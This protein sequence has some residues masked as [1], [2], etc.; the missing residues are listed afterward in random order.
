MTVLHEL[1]ETGQSPW[2]DNIT[3]DLLFSGGLKQLIDDGISGLTSNPT[4]FQKAF[5]SSPLYKNQLEEIKHGEIDTFEAYEQLAFRDI[6]DATDCFEEVYESSG[7]IDG[8]VS[9]EVSPH[10]AH[11]KEK[12]IVEARRTFS[13][14]DRPNLMIK[15]P[16]TDEGISAIMELISEGVN[17]NATLIFSVL[18]YEKTANAYIEGLEK[19]ASEG[20]DLSAL[21]SVASVFISRVD[22][23]VDKLLD[24]KGK[25][26]LKGLTAVAN[27]KMIYRKFK[28]IFSSERFRKLQEKGANV[29]RVLWASTSS[30]NPA[31]S[32]IKYVQELIGQ[33]T[34]NTMP[35][36]TMKAFIESGEARATVEDNLEEARRVLSEVESAGISVEEVCDNLQNDGVRKFIDSF[37]SLLVSI[38]KSIG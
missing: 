21:H 10:Y 29:Q 3:R 37:D 17:I 6:L 24:E 20:G 19:R 12:T 34:V 31:Y 9:I 8:Y 26:S 36:D 5:G 7:K 4:I 35:E 1:R 32:P 30:K 22:T 18:Q 23:A 15:V 28:E 14:I 38:S 33:D 11:D 25:T 13:A 2:Y 27:A 16:A